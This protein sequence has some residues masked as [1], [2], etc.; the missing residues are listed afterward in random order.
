[1]KRQALSSGDQPYGAVLVKDERIIGF[2]PSRVVKNQDTD[3]H[4]EREALRHA[5][6]ESGPQ[7]VR[8][9][10]LY[11]TSRPCAACESAAFRAGVVRMFHGPALADA[12]APRPR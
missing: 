5:L 9:S 3:A 7:G 6:S 1:M 2:G 10:V 11:S 12:G 8:G 4:A